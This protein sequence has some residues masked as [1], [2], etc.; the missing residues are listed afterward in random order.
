MAVGFIRR[1]HALRLWQLLPDAIQ[2][3][4]AEGPEL[5]HYF[6]SVEPLISRAKTYLAGQTS[7]WLTQLQ[8]WQDRQNKLEEPRAD[9]SRVFEAFTNVLIALAAQKPL[10][11]LVEDLHWADVSSIGLL[12]HL[13]RYLNR[14]RVLVLGTYRPEEIALG[15]DGVRHP[16]A[17]MLSEVKRHYGDVWID[18]D[19]SVKARQFVKAI[20]GR[21]PNRLSQRFQDALFH[22]TQGHA[23]FTVEL[24]RDMQER[25][26]LYQDK[27]GYWRESPSLDWGVLPAKVEG[28]IEKRI[29]QLSDELQNLLI[30]ASVEGEDFTA[31]V[32]S[33]VTNEPRRAMLRQLSQHLEKRHLLIQEQRDVMVNGQRLSRYRFSHVLFQQYLYQR[34]SAGERRLLHGEVATALEK[35]Y[36][37]EIDSIVV[38]LAHHFSQAEI[39]PHAFCYLLSSAH[40][41][42]QAQAPQEAIAFY[43]Q[44]IEASHHIRPSLSDEYLLPV[45]EGRG[46]VYMLL[47]QHNEA[48]A[49]FQVMCRLARSCGNRQ[50]EGEG[51]CHL[52]FAHWG[53][54][55]QEHA[56]FAEQ[57]GQEAYK[58]AQ[59]IGDERILAKSMTSLGFM[60]QWHG[61]LDQAA[62]RLETSLQISRRNGY[63]GSVSQNL[64]WL[65]VQA[66]WQGNFERAIELGEESLIISRKRYDGLQELFCLAFLGLAAGGAGNYGYALALFKE[67][68]IEAKERQNPFFMGR[69]MNQLGWV[70]SEFGDFNQALEYDLRSIEFGRISGVSNVEISAL[71]NTGLDYLAQGRYSEAQSYL[72]STLERVQKEG[73]G[74]HRWRWMMRLFIGL[75]ELSYQKG[76]YEQALTYIEAGIQE[77]KATTSR[78]YM[79]KGQ[80][81]QG[82]ILLALKQE[83]GGDLLQQAFDL[84]K[85]LRSPALI[86]PLA[87][88]L[89]QWYIDQGQITEALASYQQAQSAIQIMVQAIDDENLQTIFWQSSLVQAVQ[90]N[91][92]SM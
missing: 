84:A 63:G 7:D 90:R 26:D 33:S 29:G 23:L 15:R 71:I 31:Q 38:N 52:A 58:L 21:E 51:L 27:A 36:A 47:A 85:K 72:E 8:S 32:V 59:E 54:F 48:I 89:G 34:L 12:F 3:L 46:V 11:I 61:N 13:S 83:I 5:L 44:A 75:A 78:K 17:D 45:Y 30:V 74:S 24:I 42:K 65:S 35:L 82:K 91:L 56:P 4:L 60:H 57:Y 70:H 20:L 43:T 86:Y 18:L 92:A 9:Q 64:L 80:A 10:L 55:A 39:W 14:S 73:F 40:K 50:K 68:M 53:M 76:H 88:D 66:N 6:I 62:K 69:L 87:Y 67:G 41:A 1:D 49:D 37:E 28:V 16:L 79:V 19:H 22:H 81:L 77:A 25:G 2:A